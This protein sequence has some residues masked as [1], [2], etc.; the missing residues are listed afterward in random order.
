MVRILTDSACDMPQAQAKSKGIDIIPNIVTFPDG[1]TIRDGIDMSSDE[2][3]QYMAKAGQIPM[4]SH[5]GPEPYMRYF[6]EAKAA[7]EA[8]EWDMLDE[9]DFGNED[10]SV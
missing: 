5:P 7:L 10:A 1:K 4:T 3:Y 9:L 2:F 6:E 8:C